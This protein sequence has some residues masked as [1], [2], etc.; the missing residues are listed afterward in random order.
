MRS[1]REIRD[2]IDLRLEEIDLPLDT[3]VRVMLMS[4][5]DTAVEIMV[6]EDREHESGSITLA[7]TGR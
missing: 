4:P 6:E 5:S 7:I 3:L 1:W 2:Q